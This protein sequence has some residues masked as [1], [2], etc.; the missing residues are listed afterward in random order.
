MV[1]VGG[2]E[3]GEKPQIA[4]VAVIDGDTDVEELASKVSQVLNL[5]QNSDTKPDP[6]SKSKSNKQFREVH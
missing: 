3:N 1:W 2:K 4:F 6:D 5:I